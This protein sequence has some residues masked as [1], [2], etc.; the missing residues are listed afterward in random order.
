MISIIIRLIS[1]LNCNSPLHLSWSDTR[2]DIYIK[3]SFASGYSLKFGARSIVLSL[4]NYS[5]R[6]FYFNDLTFG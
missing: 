1:F 5:R 4:E 6:L 3:L 2:I